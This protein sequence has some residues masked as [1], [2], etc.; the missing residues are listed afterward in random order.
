M[1][2][3]ILVAILVLLIAYWWSNQGV[4]DAFIQFACVVIA[5]VLAFALWEPVTI[6]FLLSG[7]AFDNFAWGI[8][9]GGL[10]LGLLFA[11][12]FLMDWFT[13]KRP[14]LPRW[15]NLSFGAVLGLLS[16][17]LTMGI[18][19]I[20]IGHVSTSTELLGYNGWIRDSTGRPTQSDPNSPP[21]LVMGFTQGFFNM[22]SAGSCAPLIGNASLA[23]YRPNVAQDGGSLFRDSIQAGKGNSAIRANGFIIEGFYYDP[24]YSMRSSGIGAYA[25]LLTFNKESFD[26]GGSFSMSA[27]QARLIA[28]APSG[29]IAEF[30]VEFSQE[31]TVDSAMSMVRYSFNTSE[32]YATLENARD[33]GKICLVFSAKSFQNEKPTMLMIKGIR[34]MLPTVNPDTLALG[35]AL[36]NA[37]QL[38]TIA[39]DDTAPSIP[40]DELRLDSSISGMLL[41]K[42]GLPGTLQ[43]TGGS[44]FTG[45]A[46]KITKNSLAKG[47]VRTLFEDQGQ[48]IVKLT[49]SRDSTADLYNV[50][51]TRK[52][53]L[54]IGDDGVP[55]LVDTKWNFYQPYGYI[56]INSA[57]DEYDIYLEPPKDG[58][59]VKQ[60]KVAENLGGID[61]L[62]KLPIGIEIQMVILRDPRKPLAT[63]KILG[64]ANLKIEGKVAPKDDG[65]STNAEKIDG[66]ATAIEDNTKNMDEPK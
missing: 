8:S 21:T 45:A 65:K 24:K 58:F 20:A 18:T 19:L 13:L 59:T 41:S 64:T 17:I 61:V 66:S 40:S 3:S 26:P 6:G 55:I 23:S 51:K 42:N 35:R 10:F 47:D 30:P 50:D 37:G 44:L 16:G 12:R 43:E 4:F 38:T 2:L 33:D 32:S 22:L 62:Y 34:I 7:G 53:A 9:L 11:L 28:P 54:K 31:K 25:V 36:E 29:V 46:R 5:G 48:K 39:P 14:S 27:S 52:I 49:V 15:A 60:F 63:A 57:T 56:W 1:T